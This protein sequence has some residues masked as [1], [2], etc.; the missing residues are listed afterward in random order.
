MTF[1]PYQSRKLRL[2]GA[3]GD[4]GRGKA[5]DGP[6]LAFPLDP[7]EYVWDIP[8]RIINVPNHHDEASALPTR[9]V[10]HLE[11]SAYIVY[12]RQLRRLGTGA[13]LQIDAST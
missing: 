11:S 6:E 13:A 9:N 4:R 2:S 10:T 5:A 8:G 12:R 7:L 3:H 1:R